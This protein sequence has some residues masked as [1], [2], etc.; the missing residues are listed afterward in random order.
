[1]VVLHGHP[2]DFLVACGGGS[3][4]LDADVLV[5]LERHLGGTEQQRLVVEHRT[6]VAVEGHDGLS[7]VTEVE[8]EVTG[9]LV[10]AVSLTAHHPAAGLLHRAA[11]GHDSH[12][13]RTIDLADKLATALR[14]A[15]I[16]HHGRHLAHHLV[17]IYPRIEQRIEQR[18]EEDE[19]PNAL[20]PQNVHQLVVKYIA[21]SSR[22][23]H[24]GSQIVNRKYVNRKSSRHVFKLQERLAVAVVHH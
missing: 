20:I 2:R 24:C 21:Y 7:Q 23:S 14:A 1:M 12:I 4:A 17:V 11:A 9:N 15:L 22:Y 3:H 13:G 5:H 16:D 18:H 6:H 8:V 19:E 10:D